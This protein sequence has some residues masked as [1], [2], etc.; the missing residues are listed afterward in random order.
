MVSFPMNFLERTFLD[1]KV[2]L[3]PMADRKPPQLKVASV[4]DAMA[5]PPTMGKRDNTMGTVGVSPRNIAD[6][7]T[8]KKG[9]SACNKVASQ[10]SIAFTTGLLYMHARMDDCMHDTADR[11]CVHTCACN[12]TC[13][14][15]CT[16]KHDRWDTAT[17]MNLVRT[18][19]VC[20]K[21]TATR[22]RLTLVRRLP[23]VCTPARG[24]M[25]FTYKQNA[26]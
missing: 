22:P 23:K 24:R 10:V 21:D 19:M 20:V 25:P 13:H 11:S 26:V 7:N 16:A 3:D 4:T 18:L 15:I 2:M 12:P 14:A 6:S 9:S 17:C 5:T 8:L 1:W